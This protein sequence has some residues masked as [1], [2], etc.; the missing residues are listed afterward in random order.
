MIVDGTHRKHESGERKDD[1]QGSN[2]DSATTAQPCLHEYSIKEHETSKFQTQCAARSQNFEENVR[3]S[4]STT[5]QQERCYCRATGQH[6]RICERKSPAKTLKIRDLR[7]VIAFSCSRKP[8]EQT[9][10]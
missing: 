8:A 7:A 10:S 3:A 9:A 5:S 4:T 1:M 6:N 2:A